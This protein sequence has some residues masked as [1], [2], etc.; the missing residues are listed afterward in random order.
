M[1][2][3]KLAAIFYAGMLCFSGVVSGQDPV[4]TV[5]KEISSDELACEDNVSNEDEGSQKA[6]FG[7]RFKRKLMALA[8][9]LDPEANVIFWCMEHPDTAKALA[10]VMG[11]SVTTLTSWLSYKLY[12]YCKS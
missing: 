10:I 6:P 9:N 12:K 4:E 3:T 11:I 5:T 2:K 8:Y 7:T 1:K